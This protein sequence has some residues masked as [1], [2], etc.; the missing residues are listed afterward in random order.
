VIVRKDERRHTREVSVQ[1]DRSEVS[2]LLVEQVST[3]LVVDRVAADEHLSVYFNDQHAATVSGSVPIARDELLES[4]GLTPTEP[5]ETDG[6]ALAEGLGDNVT[7]TSNVV[8]TPETVAAFNAVAGDP[9]QV[10]RAERD[11][12]VADNERAPAWGA[13]VSA[14]LERIR[15]IDWSLTQSENVLRSEDVGVVLR[16]PTTSG[17]DDMERLAR[18]TLEQY[19]D[20]PVA[21]SLLKV[22]AALR[23]PWPC[24]G[25]N[26]GVQ[27]GTGE[28]APQ[29]EE[30]PEVQ[31][32]RPEDPA[33]LTVQLE[34]RA[35][36]VVRGVLDALGSLDR[37]E[38]PATLTV[39]HVVNDLRTVSTSLVKA[40]YLSDPGSEVE[41]HVHEGMTV[42]DAL[43]ALLEKY[44]D[45]VLV[46][47]GGAAQ[48]VV[49]RPMSEDNLR[50]ARVKLVELSRGTG[51]P[52]TS[53]ELH[54]V[55]ALLGGE[56]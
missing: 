7:G 51:G 25:D 23:R 50:Q 55:L 31:V 1:F 24:V 44:Q 18:A 16:G 3:N 54:Y 19:P 37:P 36:H 9:D 5:V 10:L 20:D 17:L 26:P 42:L 29:S 13:A 4:L 35:T 48:R 12:L 15:E 43:T 22:V 47:G 32:D 38:D 6:A 8:E 39:R 49:P 52:A 30:L 40:D 56:L 21:T 34:D 27:V 45:C 2:R 14:R 11:Q 46:E 41:R 53:S 33:T 28:Y